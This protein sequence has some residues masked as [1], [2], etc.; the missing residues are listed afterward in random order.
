MGNR[1]TTAELGMYKEKISKA[2]FQNAE[3]RELILGDTSGMNAAA[4]RKAFKEHVK[5]HLFIDDTIT[6]TTTYIFYDVFCPSL[7]TNT[8]QCKIVMYIIC[9]RDILDNYIK[10]GYYGNRADILTQMVENTLVNDEKIANEFGIGK[11][12]LDSID[13]YNSSRL[14][15][16]S[17]TFS[18]PNYR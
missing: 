16:R 10:D 1:N 5:S 6:E 17:L 9:H 2:L 4:L 7:R 11:L 18:V 3:I 14:Y 12:T 13:I 15:G 8:K